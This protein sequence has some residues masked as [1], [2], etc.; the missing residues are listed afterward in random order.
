M[1]P[2]TVPES[3]SD[4]ATDRRQRVKISLVYRKPRSTANFSV[5]ASFDQML[6]SFPARP[7]WEVE[8]VV[9]AHYS[10]GVIPRLRAVRDLAH[11]RADLYHITGDVHF[12]A[13]G[14]AGRRSILTV[15]DCGFTYDQPIVKRWLLKKLWL[16]WPVRMCRRVTAVSEATRQDILRQTQCP[17]AKVRVIPTVIGDHFRPAPQRPPAELPRILHI[18]LARNKNFQ[19]HVEALNGLRCRLH[20]V[21]KLEELHHQWLQRHRI[22]YTHGHNLSAAEMQQAYEQ[23]D[24][25]L[26]ASTR[27]GFGMP[28]VE[29]QTV[30]RPVVTSRISSMPEVAGDGA[31]LV[32]PFDVAAI[33]VGVSKVLG[34]AAFRES[35]VRRGFA[36][37]QRFR[38]ETVARQYAD[39]YA[40]VL[41][42]P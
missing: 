4:L 28:I 13:L 31:C 15:H 7:D 10:N 1:R 38:P 9:S 39:L 42:E 33:R 36:N 2:I 19:R 16:D 5:E 25:L 34:D 3:G 18:G 24:L 14:L 6:A 8:K 11:L 26:F 22:D 20:I 23:S 37:A 12:L 29:A 41:R 32:D 21:G 30:G 40:E 35:L 17:P 27:E